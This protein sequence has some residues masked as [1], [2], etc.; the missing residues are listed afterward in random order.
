MELWDAPRR[1][2]FA[3]MARFLNLIAVE[4]DIAKVPVMVGGQGERKTLRL[5]AKYADA[6]NVFAGRGSGPEQVAHKLAVLRDWC[7]REGRRYDDIRRTVLYNGPVEPA[8][9]GAFLE[10]M[11]ALADLGVDEVHVMP[12]Q[13]DP[14]GFVRDLGT[15]VVPRLSQI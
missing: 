8:R 12:M 7:D 11:R 15:H 2:R 3:M 10:E 14:V 4:P 6:C 1:R 9:A 5:V 13:G